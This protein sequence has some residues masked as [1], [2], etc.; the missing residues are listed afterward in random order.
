MIK[1]TLFPCILGL[2]S[3]LAGFTNSR[4]IAQSATV[5]FTGNITPTCF[6]D[7][8]TLG[9]LIS[10]DSGGVT[11]LDD[12]LD[13][14]S[15]PASVNV[16]CNDDFRLTLNTPQ[17]VSAPAGFIAGSFTCTA[18]AFSSISIPPSFLLVSDV[19]NGSST[20]ADDIGI[21]GSVNAGLINVSMTVSQGPA[22]PA[23]N[24]TFTVLLD[25]VPL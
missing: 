21:D 8:P 5:P 15:N 17:L 11:G 16:F 14:D 23:G 20:D 4:A 6:F 22:L 12:T 1:N 10:S 18:V 2:A 3:L 7:T 9:T 13:A 19:C 24:Y 25:A